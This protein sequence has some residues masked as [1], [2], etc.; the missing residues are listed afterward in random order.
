MTPVGEL[1]LIQHCEQCDVMIYYDLIYSDLTCG[2]KPGVCRFH[3]VID[4]KS[5]Y[6]WLFDIHLAVT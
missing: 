2:K 1:L 6:S 5:I 3:S 4:F